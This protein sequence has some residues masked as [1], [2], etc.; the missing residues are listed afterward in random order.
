MYAN[1]R[2]IQKWE[3]GAYGET[4]RLREQTR[5]ESEMHNGL[6]TVGGLIIPTG[7]TLTLESVD[8]PPEEE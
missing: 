7:G 8:L 6:L 1:V 5:F 4:V 2:V 3:A